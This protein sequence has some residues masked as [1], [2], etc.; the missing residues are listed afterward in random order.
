ML[1]QRIARAIGPLR[2]AAPI[3]RRARVTPAKTVGPLRRAATIKLGVTEA[4]TEAVAVLP[5]AAVRSLPTAPVRQ[6]ILMTPAVAI[7]PLRPAATIGRTVLITLAVAVPGGGPLGPLVRWLSSA[8]RVIDVAYRLPERIGVGIVSRATARVSWTGIPARDRVAR[9]S[10]SYPRSDVTFQVRTRRWPSPRPVG[11]TLG[12]PVT[13]GRLCWSPS[14]GPAGWSVLRSAARRTIGLLTRPGLGTGAGRGPGARPARSVGVGRRQRV[15]SDWP[16][17]AEPALGVGIRVLVRRL[18]IIPPPAHRYLHTRQ[19]DSGARR[20]APRPSRQVPPLSVKVP[21]RAGA[22]QPTFEHT[23]W[24]SR[25][26]RRWREITSFPS[27]V[28]LVLLRT[29]SGGDRVR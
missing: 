18:A 29:L 9:R 8:G 4:V 10:G 1:E 21:M 3:A 2:A 26:G 11:S 7:R 6:R 12:A 13:A 25:C 15:G 17:I 19:P 27:W 28:D 24:L 23:E 14:L 5:P 16:E 22:S 20:T